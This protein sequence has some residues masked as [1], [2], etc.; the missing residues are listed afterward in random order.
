[1]PAVRRITMFK[2]PGE[3]DQQKVL[4]MYKNM[5]TKALKVCYHLPHSALMFYAPNSAVKLITNTI[6]QDGQQYIIAVEA[7]ITQQDQRAQGYTLAATTTFKSQE[8]F[9]YYDK[10]C[11]AHLELKTFARSVAQGLCMVY[12]SLDE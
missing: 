1:M 7:G 11:K 2:I 6:M 12:F 4:S 9:E 8:D 3:E 10:E 5:Q